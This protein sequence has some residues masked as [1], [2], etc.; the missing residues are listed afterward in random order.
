MVRLTAHRIGINA[1][2][3][4]EMKQFRRHITILTGILLMLL[5]LCVSCSSQ[6]EAQETVSK[7]NIH[8]YGPGDM[9]S[10]RADADG[11]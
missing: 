5:A 1:I 11:V 6:D 10:T 7:L 9:N 2:N 8:I 3:E 4:N